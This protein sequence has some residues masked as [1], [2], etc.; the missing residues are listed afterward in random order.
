MEKAGTINK[1]E[2][3]DERNIDTDKKFKKLKRQATRKQRTKKKQALRK[4]LKKNDPN[5][6]ITIQSK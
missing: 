4:Y 3:R 1:T 6:S 2:K 5:L